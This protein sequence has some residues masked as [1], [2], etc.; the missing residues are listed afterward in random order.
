MNSNLD[1]RGVLLLNLHKLF[2]MMTGMEHEEVIW[3]SKVL[4][5][6]SL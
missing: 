1:L 4:W 2:T 3:D 5:V 6:S